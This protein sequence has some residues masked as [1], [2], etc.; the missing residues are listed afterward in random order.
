MP[1]SDDLAPATIADNVYEVSVSA[2]TTD[3]NNI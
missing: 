3:N 1:N 2:E